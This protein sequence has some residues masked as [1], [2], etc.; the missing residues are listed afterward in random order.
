MEV[1][2][3][4]VLRVYSFWNLNAKDATDVICKEQSA[5]PV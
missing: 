5:E 3:V 4:K 2:A 1:A